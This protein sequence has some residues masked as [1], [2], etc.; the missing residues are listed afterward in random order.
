MKAWNRHIGAKGFSLVELFVAIIIAG[1]LIAMG[2]PSFLGLIQRSSMNAGTRQVMYEIRAVQSLAVTRGGV[3]GFHWGG[4]PLVGFP[5][6]QYRIIRD[7]TGACGFPAPGAPQDGTDVVRT[8]FDLAGEYPG[9]VVQSV[10]DNVGTVLG[11][12]MFNSRGASVNTCAAV[13][14]PVTVTVAD[15]SG[16]T[17]TVTIQRAGRVTSP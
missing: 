15:A 7:T 13:T 1:I 16:V 8:W 6:S 14:F 12:V 2:L 10:R 17:R 3:F 11:G 9:I 5:P 4:D